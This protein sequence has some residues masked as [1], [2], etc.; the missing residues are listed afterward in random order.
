MPKNY[1]VTCSRVTVE[2]LLKNDAY[3]ANSVPPVP[4]GL[5]LRLTISTSERVTALIM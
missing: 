1:L 4:P 3:L 2:L 5:A